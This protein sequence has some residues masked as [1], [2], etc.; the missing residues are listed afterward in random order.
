MTT[1]TYT[2]CDTAGSPSIALCYFCETVLVT[3]PV[4]LRVVRSHTI[5][6][7]VSTRRFCSFDCFIQWIQMLQW[8]R[9]N[10]CVC[11]LDGTIDEGIFT[12]DFE[13]LQ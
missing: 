9:A 7:T 1:V 11:V 12:D 8:A 13:F 4:Y 10:Y 5:G 3:K 6:H 2:L